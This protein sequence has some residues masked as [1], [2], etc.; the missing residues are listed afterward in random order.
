M[1]KE[2]IMGFIEDGTVIDH[3]PEGLVFQIGLL[4]GVDK[5]R[6]GRVSLGDGYD[7]KQTRTGK[8]GILKIE[9]FQLDDYQLNLVALV[10]R[11]VTIN[12]V[13]NGQVRP[14]D[15]KHVEIPNFLED[16]VMCVNP[17]CVSNNEYEQLKYRI[18][19]DSERGLFTCEYCDTQ[20][21]SNTIKFIER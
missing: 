15:K 11:D 3:I 6:D 7:S 9:G 12:T 8:K 19:Y 5:M 18:N 21:D 2:R 10:A 14:E 13:R 16:V 20:F 4:L 1:S 17:G